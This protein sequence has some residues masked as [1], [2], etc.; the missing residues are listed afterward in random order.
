MVHHLKS[1][2]NTYKKVFGLDFL[3]AIYLIIRYNINILIC[4]VLRDDVFM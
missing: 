4:G 3:F 2:S 1:K